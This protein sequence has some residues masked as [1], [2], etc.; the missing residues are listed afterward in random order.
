MI[1]D[2]Q[3]SETQNIVLENIKEMSKGGK[4]F[5]EIVKADIA[6]KVSVIA[7]KQ[8]LGEQISSKRKRRSVESYSNTVSS[9]T[10]AEVCS[11]PL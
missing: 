10:P 8:I 11:Y 7:K 5:P 2:V 4:R 9:K 3:D 1:D 6:Q